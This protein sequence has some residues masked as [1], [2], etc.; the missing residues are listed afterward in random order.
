MRKISALTK[1]SIFIIAGLI[2]GLVISSQLGI[3]NNGFTKRAEEQKAP[4]VTEVPRESLNVLEAYSN[5]MV[6]VVRSVTPSV[7]NIS[8]TQTVVRRGQSPGGL[9]NDPFFRRF[10]GDEFSRQ[11]GGPREEQRSGL[12]SG[13]IVDG[14]GY[15]LTNN[16]VVKDAD[17]IKVTL[18]DT[19]EFEGK[20]IGTDPKTDLAVIQIDQKDMP[21]IKWGD[22][23]TLRVG[24]TVIAVGSPYGLN[25]TVTQ[26][27]VS[28]TGRANVN[29]ADYEDFIQTDA[30]INPGNSGGPLINIRGELVGINTAIFSTS[31]GY[32]GIGFAIPSNMVKVIMDSLIKYQKVVRGWLGVSIQ[33]V[34]EELAKEFKLKSRAGALVSDV[35][36]DSPAE[37]GGIKR[38]DIIVEFEG[39]EIE[40]SLSLRNTVASTGPGTKAKVIVIRDGKKVKLTIE[41]G[42]L[43]GEAAAKAGD[44]DNA[45]AGVSVQDL[46]P[47]LRQKLGISKRV[48]GVLV[49][50]P[51]E[52]TGLKQGDVILEVNRVPVENTETYHSV[53]SRISKDESVLL[54]VNRNGRIFYM[55]NEGE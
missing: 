37:K 3:E 18:S 20:V 17:T 46:T 11:F 39:K 16:H 32:Q 43:P 55:T 7:V 26:G 34:S 33:T 1:A 49:A 9:F 13:V 25:Q 53:V 12:G 31:G 35:M 19:R 23:D 21:A 27:I 45:L 10:F 15:I 2:I 30:A 52:E 36:E 42:E 54:L 50:E 40:D 28:A 29:I 6:D 41:I 5:A 24:E 51:G 44:Y 22:S 47:D 8:T 48:K 38:G 14:G 4:V